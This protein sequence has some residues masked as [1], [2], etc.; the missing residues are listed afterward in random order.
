MESGLGYWKKI[1]PLSHE[2]QINLPPLFCTARRLSWD[3]C[4]PYI[5]TPP[6][7]WNMGRRN[8]PYESVGQSTQMTIIDETSKL[9]KGD[10]FP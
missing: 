5:L 7:I 10:H 8:S 4:P 9:S 3:S 6:G 2:D 1:E